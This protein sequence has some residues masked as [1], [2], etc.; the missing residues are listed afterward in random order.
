MEEL[1]P[2]VV[3]RILGIGIT[4]TVVSTWVV[5]LVIMGASYFLTKRQPIA[6][7]MMVDFINDTVSDMMGRP[8]LRQLSLIGT[9][10]IFIAFSNTVAVF[11]FI[12]PPTSD[13]NVPLALALV[14]FFSVHYFGIRN[15]GLRNYVR[16][17]AQP[18]FLFPFEVLSQLTRTVSLTL[19]LFGNVLSIE[20]I[21]AIIFSLVPLFVPLPLSGFGIFTGLLQAYIFTVL[22]AVY[23]SA[24]LDV[25]EENGKG[26]PR[27]TN[28]APQ[29]G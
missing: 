22:A 16:D 27:P 20:L 8:A 4:N 6:L 2:F 15:K 18:A 24:G 17:L 26:G 23:I 21:V 13:I 9:L 25:V 5:M 29:K 7:E 28:T 14:V 11:P 10:F 3:F 19:R 1:T 12:S